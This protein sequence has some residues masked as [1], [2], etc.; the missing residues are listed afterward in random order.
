M[1]K[2][3]HAEIYQKK[4]GEHFPVGTLLRVHGAKG[5]LGIGEV[6]EYESGSAVK[7]VKFL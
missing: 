5:F 6:R 3:F 7:I 1:V 4:I 2:Y